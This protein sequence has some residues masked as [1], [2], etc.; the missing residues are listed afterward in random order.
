MKKQVIA[1]VSLILCACMLLFA[2]CK[3]KSGKDETTTKASDTTTALDAVATTAPDTTENSTEA[4]TQAETRKP[5][6][7]V[8]STNK[9][10]AQKVT[11]PKADTVKK[12]NSY[13]WNPAG[14]YKCGNGD[15]YL[16]PGVYYILKTGSKCTLTMTN[17]QKDEDGEMMGFEDVEVPRSLFIE[18]KNGY[19]ISIKGGKIIHSSKATV[20]GAN[21]ASGVYHEGAYRV[22]KDLPAGEYL[23]YS[24]SG[25]TIADCA[26][27]KNPDLFAEDSS[28]RG[29]SAYT[30]VY[31]TL[32][33]GEYVEIAGGSLK[34][35]SSSPI[36]RPDKDGAYDDICMYKVGK[37][38]QPGKYKL[39][40]DDADEEYMYAIYKDSYY[41]DA[42]GVVREDYEATGVVELNLKD[43]QYIEFLGAKLVPVTETPDPTDPTETTTATDTTAAEDPAPES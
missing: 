6:A 12:L 29:V 16:V 9:P 13:E 26:V 17:G 25:E 5:A 21:N 40:P 31:I 39:V 10:T 4:S 42:S 27:Y 23:V 37:D 32:D 28:F 22:G 8:T 35:A 15:G 20:S 14:T 34:A 19:T 11:E 24:S 1:A 36:A 43:G 7:S 2:G 30:P 18:L 33:N 38:I 3:T 41:R